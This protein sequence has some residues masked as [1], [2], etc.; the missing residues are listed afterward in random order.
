[1]PVLEATGVVTSTAHE[2]QATAQRPMCI[3]QATIINVWGW[4]K[5]AVNFCMGMLSH[6]ESCASQ[7]LQHIEL[8]HLC[9]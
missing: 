3:S 6:A 5:Q 1:M 2:Q 7:L 8:Q 4:V 9:I